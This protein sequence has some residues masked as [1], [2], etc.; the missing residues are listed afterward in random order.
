MTANVRCAGHPPFW[1][2]ATR[3]RDLSHVRLKPCGWKG[4]R[5]PTLPSVM[6]PLAGCAI[7]RTVHEVRT[8]K[9]CPRCGGRVELIREA[10]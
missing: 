4:T 10:P 2:E 1:S 3:T 5:T 9:P 7:C 6:H 8:A